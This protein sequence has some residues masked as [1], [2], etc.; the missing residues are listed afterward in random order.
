MKGGGSMKVYVVRVTAYI[1]YP[2]IREC[3]EKASSFAV[4]IKRGGNKYRKEERVKRRKIDKMSVLAT[5]GSM[6]R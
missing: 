4:A 1:P 6:L 3:T 2:I 5:S